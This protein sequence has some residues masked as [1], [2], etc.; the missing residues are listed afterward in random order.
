MGQITETDKQLLIEYL[1]DLTT[2]RIAGRDGRD[3]FDV[4][5]SRTIF[6]GVL[7]MPRDSQIQA[8]QSGIVTRDAPVGTS[9]GL[10]FRIRPTAQNG[11]IRLQVKPRWSVYYP[12]FPS[13]EETASA[14]QVA[15][16]AEELPSSEI[17]GSESDTEDPNGRSDTQTTESKAKPNS[18]VIPRKWR[19][20]DIR[21][22]ALLINLAKGHTSPFSEVGTVEIEKAFV[23]TKRQIS[24]DAEIWKHLGDPE[25]CERALSS[26]TALNSKE[27]YGK[28]VARLGKKVSLPPWSAQIVVESSPDPDDKDV[29]RV[30]ILLANTTPEKPNAPDAGLEERSLFDAALEVQFENATIVPFDFWLAPKDYRTNP[31]LPAKGI[32][33]VALWDEKERILRTEA[34]PVYRQPLYRSRRDVE[35]GFDLLESGDI[36]SELEGLAKQ[37]DRYLQDWNDFLAQ[38]ALSRF[39]KK[40]IEACSTDR[41]QFR[42]EIDRFRLGIETLKRDSRLERSFRFMNHVF[43]HL[44]LKSGGRVRA[45]RLF[46]IGFIVSQLPAL[47]VR[48]L[49]ASDNDEYAQSLRAA[50]D[51]V[52]VLW[53][54]TGGGK[55]EAYLGLIATALIYDRL[56][57]KLRGVCAWMRF[58]LRMLSLQQMERLARVIAALN[59]FRSQEP[60]LNIGDPFAIGYYVGDANTPNSLSEEEMKRYE[61]NKS[62]REEARLLRKCPF[63]G[64]QI[65]IKPLRDRWRLA[66]VCI[67]SSCFSN[68]SDSLGIYKGSLPVC[69][70]DNEIYRY[71]PAVLVGTVDKLAIIARNR[72]F[73]HLVRGARQ[74]CPRHGYTSYDE[75]I[76]RWSGC[77]NANKNLS[78][79]SP[80]RDPGI[81]LLIQDELHLLRAELGVFNGHYE[82][83]LRYLGERSHLRPKILAATA[84]IEAYD[85]QAFHIY[86][87]KS[88]RYPQP[89]WKQGESFYATSKPEKNRRHY[90][91]ILAHTRAIEEA[92]LRAVTVYQREI[93]QLIANP[94]KAAEIMRRPDLN[95]SQILATLR[96]Y[97]LSLCYVNRKSTGGSLVD[98]LGQ[99]ERSFEAEKLGTLKSQLLTGDQTIDEIGSTLDR[100]ERELDET[101]EPRLSAVA[102]TSLIS[103]GVDLERINMMV[104]CGMPSHYAEYVQCSSRAAR[105]HPGV[106]FV[107]FKARDPRETS[108]F[109]F[110]PAMHEH[111]DRLIEAVAV[112]RFASFA[113]RKTVPGL[114][115][116]LLLCDLTPDLYGTRITKPLDHVPT[117]QVALGRAPAPKKGTEPNCVQ[118]S[119]LREAIDR[120]IGVDIV[121]P[122][123]SSAQIENLRKQVHEVIDEQFGA[124]GRSIENQLKVVLD[125]ITSFRDVDEGVDFGSIDS[126]NF[127]TR[128]RAR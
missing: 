122:P 96:L 28:A 63:C 88:R 94:R 2:A 33:C 77:Q 114:L 53:F 102:A 25:K 95:D 71:L 118:E 37:M 6:A 59:E 16:A 84:T 128:L 10:D 98:K 104:V 119:Y 30:Q 9:L 115:A 125:P 34:L 3:L 67:N 18:V 50:L 15:P 93:R 11:A 29:M 110:F 38:E 105:S 82:G 41:N 20:K 78:K 103:H 112:N 92:A 69:I 12:V 76:E 86:L 79:L 23:D 91:G 14:N 124:I 74:Q 83:L 61:Y 39:D 73:A 66:H 109:E 7:Q 19:R 117:L 51:E 5:P 1:I 40:G 107:C 35:I 113:P 100:I 57:A 32:N 75:C 49:Q 13:F 55:T 116:G 65:E 99:V 70:V 64:S 123:A 81:S 44:A 80:S 60:S 56:R 87:S 97:D 72:Y 89:S 31:K 121:R 36:I 26:P 4:F 85:T 58:P 21:M 43:G 111:M 24:E 27:S 42:I 17:E 22:E 62:L 90:V 108:Q 47:A 48:E 68:Q 120:V 46:Q 101:G 8:A 54:P 52:A 106:V 126:A 127:V 45:W